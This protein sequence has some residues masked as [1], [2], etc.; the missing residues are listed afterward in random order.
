MSLPIVFIHRDDEEH[1]GLCMQQAKTSNPSSRVILIGS[2][3]NKHLCGN[4]IEHH[5]LS[6]YNQSAQTFSI[7]YKHS[8]NVDTYAYNLF[9][10]LR[11]FILRDFMRSQ[12]IERCWYF[13]SDVMLYTDI[14]QLDA[15]DLTNFEIEYTWTTPCELS[16]LDQLCDYMTK[17]FREHL[18]YQTLLAYAK[19][20]GDVPVSDMVLFVFFHNYALRRSA[21]YGM[22]AGG[23]FDHNLNCPFP[24]FTAQIH[25][26]DNKKQIYQKNGVLYG[27]F[28]DKEDYLKVHTLHFQGHAKAYIPY[29]R[30]QNI[31]NTDDY[32]YFDYPTCKWVRA[33]P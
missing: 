10:F 3:D 32:M 28:I 25:S 14:S 26:L 23:F 5:L 30:S 20:N 13:D 16:M 7:H 6:K 18:H 24:P 9:C 21:T 17:F 12:G 22:I 27:K 4:N 11:W 2:P 33:E 31:P 1:V 29:F 15:A 19:E 8:S